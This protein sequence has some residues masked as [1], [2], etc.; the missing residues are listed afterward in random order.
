MK[1]AAIYCRLAHADQSLLDAQ[2][3]RLCTFAEANGYSNFEIYSDNGYNG[4]SFDRPAFAKLEADIQDGTVGVVIVRDD[5]RISRDIYAV[6]EWIERLG[7][8]G[9]AFVMA[10]TQYTDGPDIIRDTFQRYL[11]QQKKL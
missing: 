6:M 4:L 3:E 11:E 1:M 2:K 7:E 5:T 9:V 10:D 8:Q